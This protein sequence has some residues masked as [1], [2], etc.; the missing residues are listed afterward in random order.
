MMGVLY[1]L[2][3]TRVSLEPCVMMCQHL[4]HSSFSTQYPYFRTNFLAPPYKAHSSEFLI[5]LCP[6]TKP[7]TQNLI[8]V[9]PFWHGARGSIGRGSEPLHTVSLL[10]LFPLWWGPAGILVA[11]PAQSS[12]VGKAGSSCALWSV[13][14]LSNGLLAP[15]PFRPGRLQE[16]VKTKTC[17]WAFPVLSWPAAKMCLPLV[18]DVCYLLQT[19]FFF[20]LSLR[21]MCSSFLFW[22]SPFPPPSTTPVI[23]ESACERLEFTMSRPYKG[24][25]S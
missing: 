1:L 3:V 5:S 22:F 4:W 12:G 20:I 16:V 25:V 13:S 2:P 19:F 14:V 23:H 24:W 11:V 8:L 9:V 6:F 7:N 17:S 18:G 15:L 21:A 10:K